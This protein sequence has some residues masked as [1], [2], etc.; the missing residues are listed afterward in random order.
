MIKQSRS[1][2]AGDEGER[3][4]KHAALLRKLLGLHEQVWSCCVNCFGGDNPLLA[5]CLTA[6]CLSAPLNGLSPSLTLVAHEYGFNDQER[7]TYLGGYVALSTMIGQVIGSLLAGFVVDFFNRRDLLLASLVIGAGAMILFGLISYFPALL[8]LRVVSGG[9]QAAVVPVLFSL[10]ADYY[11]ADKGRAT[12]SAIVSSCLGGGM[13]LGQLFTGYFLS[14]LGWR[15]PFICMG[16]ATLLSA[17][18]IYST[19]LEPPARGAREDAL[20]EVISKGVSA[21]PPMSMKTFL[22]SVACVPT[23]SMMLLQTIPNTIPWGV[24]SAHLHD[25]LATD[26]HLSMPQATSLIAVFGT[27]AALGGLFGGFI[28]AKFY[29]F[30]RALLPI[31][32]G[33]TTITSALFLQQLLAMNLREA[34]AMQVAVPVL[35]VSGALAAVNGANIRVIVLNLTTPEAR[36]AVI[37]F[38]NLV[39]GIGRGFGPSLIEHWMTTNGLGRKE[40][41]SYFLSLWLVSG[42]MLCLSSVFVAKDEA[43]FIARLA[44][45]AAFASK[46]RQTADSVDANPE[47]QIEETVPA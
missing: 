17:L 44:S 43:R 23:V 21:L 12:N 4:V 13:M 47:C 36:G 25:L 42:S 20:L 45:F 16:V 35:I 8:L 15:M 19:M 14:T 46:Q 7:D 3:G 30:R 38:L 31:F 29:S 22:S 5:L 18:Y 41:V 11:S 32:M 9:C 34:G 1:N 33:A 28:G 6:S 2:D 40:S 37:A 39:N 27:G 26:A 24:L 10:I